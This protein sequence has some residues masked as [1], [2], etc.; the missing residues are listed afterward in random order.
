MSSRD[1]PD[2]KNLAKGSEEKDRQDETDGTSAHKTLAS[3]GNV[4]ATVEGGGIVHVDR[5]VPFIVLYAGS[6]GTNATKTAAY[7]IATA[8]PSYL[9]TQQ[10]DAVEQVRKNVVD[11]LKKRLAMF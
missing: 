6:A 1:K 9:T 3:E 2:G 8:G 10:L 7:M 5:P 4:R 11:T